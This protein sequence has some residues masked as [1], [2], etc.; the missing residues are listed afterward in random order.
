VRAFRHGVA[1]QKVAADLS[2]FRTEP[3]DGLE[4]RQLLINTT[5]SMGHG[6]VCTTWR[7]YVHGAE[8]L[9]AHWLDHRLALGI[10]MPNEAKP[11]PSWKLAGPGVQAKISWKPPVF[12]EAA[13]FLAEKARGVDSLL[14]ARR[15]D[16]PDTWIIEIE[17]ALIELGIRQLDSPAKTGQLDINLW[18]VKVAPF[19]AELHTTPGLV[20]AATRCICIGK[21]SLADPESG[22]LRSIDPAVSH[23]C[24]TG[25]WFEGRVDSV[26]AQ[27]RALASFC[28]R[29]ALGLLGRD[30]DCKKPQS[31]RRSNGGAF[32]ARGTHNHQHRTP[33]RGRHHSHLSLCSGAAH[34]TSAEAQV[35]C[36]NPQIGEITCQHHSWY[37]NACC[38]AIWDGA[39]TR[40]LYQHHSYRI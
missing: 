3:R 38:S 8:L 33:F 40:R 31:T 20:S 37:P 18:I 15:A 7:H 19:I 13:T 14:A 26:P 5:I 29:K 25:S 36:L 23:R 16:L 11:P 32:R 28:A 2:P 9:M 27:H 24:S 39:G 10:Q 6:H 30:K 1:S 34:D 17:E 12:L 4:A 21:D 35:Q 22:R